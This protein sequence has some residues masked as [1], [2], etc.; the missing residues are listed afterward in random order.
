MD[1][2]ACVKIL[3]KFSSDIN[4]LTKSQFKII[5]GFIYKIGVKTQVMFKSMGKYA[6][7]SKGIY[8]FDS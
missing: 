1:E 8:V 5:V 7:I 4:Y 2:I 3:F 6:I